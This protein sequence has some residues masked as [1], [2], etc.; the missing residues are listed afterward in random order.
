M[1]QKLDVGSTFFVFLYSNYYR[2]CA[3]SKSIRE[4]VGTRNKKKGVRGDYKNLR[5]KMKGE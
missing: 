4:C 2:L 1:E 5:L 3:P